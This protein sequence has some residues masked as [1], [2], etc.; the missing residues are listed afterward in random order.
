M[1]TET[2]TTY[3]KKVWF[4][5]V[6]AL[7]TIFLILATLFTNFTERHTDLS[8]SVPMSVGSPEFVT[9]VEAVTGSVRLPVEGEIVVF[10]DGSLFLTDLL[11]EIRGAQRSVTITNYIFRDGTMTG[12]IFDE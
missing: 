4:L 9:A 5:I 2:V 8:S 3:P 7:A 12:A 11:T 10:N 6:F 1:A